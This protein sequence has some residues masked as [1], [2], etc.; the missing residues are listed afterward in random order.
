MSNGDDQRN[1]EENEILENHD[2]FVEAPTLEGK[3]RILGENFRDGR[4]ATV[5]SFAA[6]RRL[7]PWRPW[8]VTAAGGFSIMVVLGLVW[9]ASAFA[10]DMQHSKAAAEAAVKTAEEAKQADIDHDANLRADMKPV[11]EGVA[12]IHAELLMILR[13]KGIDEPTDRDIETSRKTLGFGP[14]TINQDSTAR[15]G[16]EDRE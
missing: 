6:L 4:L 13:S 14:D 15:R 12:V 7:L 16:P 3:V 8:M 11:S 10:K 9:G 1:K 5:R 2:R